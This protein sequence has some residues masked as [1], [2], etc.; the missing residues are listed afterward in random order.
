[1]TLPPVAPVIAIFFGL[2]VCLTCYIF[3]KALRFP[4]MLL[5]MFLGWIL[6]QSLVSLTGYYLDEHGLPPPFLFLVIP[7]LTLIVAALLLPGLRSSL[8]KVDPFMLTMVHIIRVPV[9]LVLWALF[10]HRLVPE[11]MTFA[12]LNYDILAGL[13]SPFIAY[14]AFRR[15]TFSRLALM[16]WHFLCLVLL[17]NVVGHGVLSAPTPFQQLSF[18]QPNIGLLYFP[19]VFL[20]GLIVPVVLFSHLAEIRRLFLSRAVVS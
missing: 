12:G 10:I 9:E 19:F 17:L 15:R 3:L 11:A 18:D 2:T 14:F 13:T 20:P 1:M 16:T 6:L 8:E 5:F 7:P 4:R